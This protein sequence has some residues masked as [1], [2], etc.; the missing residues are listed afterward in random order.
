MSREEQL[1]VMLQLFYEALGVRGE[2]GMEKAE[3]GYEW[4]EVY[5]M[6]GEE[7]EVVM[8]EVVGESDV[9]PVG[10]KLKIMM[11]GRHVVRPFPSC[12]G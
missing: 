5:E 11:R 1:E 9:E 3:G 10:G 7:K 12:P 8:R 6:L 4:E 2:E